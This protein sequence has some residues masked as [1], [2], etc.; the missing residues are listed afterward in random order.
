MDSELLTL[1]A[2]HG[3][4]EG[5]RMLYLFLNLDQPYGSSRLT[6]GL[7]NGRYSTFL[8]Y[9]VQW[10]LGSTLA[11]ELALEE[12]PSRTIFRDGPA[13]MFN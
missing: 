5:S 7:F 6:G 4:N 12:Q 13:S 8:P 11:L 1:G 2:Y 9:L 3:L 10:G